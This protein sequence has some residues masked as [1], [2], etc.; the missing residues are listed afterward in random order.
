MHPDVQ[1]QR[2][3]KKE[4]EKRQRGQKNQRKRGKARSGYHKSKYSPGLCLE[5]RGTEAVRETTPYLPF[6]DNRIEDT[7][8]IVNRG[9]SLN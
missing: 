4:G 6:D 7:P 3:A 5:H 8:D 2:E 1:L 9:V